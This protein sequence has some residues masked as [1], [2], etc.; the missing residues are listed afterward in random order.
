MQERGSE[1]SC[2]H[3]GESQ[4]HPNA[5]KQEWRNLLGRGIGDPGIS[6]GFANALVCLSSLGTRAE[7]TVQ[8]SRGEIFLVCTVLP[9]TDMSYT[10]ILTA[11]KAC[12]NFGSNYS[13]VE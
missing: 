5:Q 12:N 13:L 4:S 2:P 9:V 3:S 6:R 10:D 7:L 1:I 11:L 8:H